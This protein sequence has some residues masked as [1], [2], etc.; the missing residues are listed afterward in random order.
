MAAM[1]CARRV[2][3]WALVTSVLGCGAAPPVRDPSAE[4]LRARVGG[5]LP[6]TVSLGEARYVPVSARRDEKRFGG[7]LEGA[8]ALVNGIRLIELPNGGVLSATSPLPSGGVTES[9]V[10]EV[11]SRMGGGF[12][13]LIGSSVHRADDWLSP[14][15]PIFTAPTAPAS[16]IVR[17]TVGLDRVYLQLDRGTWVPIDP[18]DGQL[19]DLGTFPRAP[20]VTSL[21]TLDGWRAAALADARGVVVT[22]DAGATWTPIP[23][24]ANPVSL[25]RIGDMLVVK[26]GDSSSS[27]RTAWF[28]INTD[29]RVGRLARDPAEEDDAPTGELEEAPASTPFGVRPLVAAIE[30]GW[31]LTDGTALVARDGAIGRVRMSDGA[32]VEIARDVFPLRPARCHPFSL[33]RPTSPAAFGFACGTPRGATE[34]YAYDA[35]AGAPTLLRRFDKPRV[36]ASSGNGA[37][38]IR[39]ACAQDAPSDDE[40]RSRQTYCVLGHDNRFTDFVVQGEIGAQRIVVLA[41]GR[42]A[43]IAPP[44]AGNLAGASVT[45]LDKGVAK[46]SP[47]IWEP[48]AP[49]ERAAIEHV[50][51]NGTWLESFEERKPGKLSGWVVTGHV[52]I[53]IEIGADGHARHGM[54]VPDMGTTI[55]SSAYGIGWSSHGYETIDG[56]MT[57]HQVDMPLTLPADNRSDVRAACGPLGCE[58]GGWLRVGWGGHPNQSPSAPQTIT[59]ER[60]PGYS[61][62]HLLCEAASKLTVQAQ[63]YVPVPPKAKSYEWQAFYGVN[64]PKLVD[65]DYAYG[66][67]GP[68]VLTGTNDTARSRRTGDS[69]VRTLAHYYAWGPRSLDWETKG[70]SMAR[71]SSPFEPS[72]S[73]HSTQLG[74]IPHFVGLA[75]STLVTQGRF[76]SVLDA[77]GVAFGDDGAHALWVFAMRQGNAAGALLLEADRGATEIRRTDGY[78]LGAIDSAVRAG[79]RWYLTTPND[80]DEP[81]ATIVWEVEA[82]VAHELARLPRISV[83][84]Q[85]QQSTA[86]LGVRI[87][88]SADNRAVGVVIDGQPSAKRYITNQRWVVPIDLAT[89]KVMEPEPIGAADATSAATICEPGAGGWVMDVGYTNP[90][91]IGTDSLSSS[92]ARVHLDHGAACIERV[93]STSEIDP[94]A[95]SKHLVDADSPSVEVTAM[96]EGVRVLLHCIRSR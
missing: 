55:V 39:G 22:T 85:W 52:A 23:L 12:L 48:D 66:L 93:I 38:W 18:K 65:D 70:R 68:S 81:N 88:R 73:V 57:W 76:G 86:T 83:P 4:Q 40:A 2:V 1:R 27:D 77:G 34:I 3:A 24:P 69:N 87:A 47:I 33:A 45:V 60:S 54:F 62:L 14:T 58:A 94:L 90:L 71:W 29:G 72:T 75:V 95:L 15:H 30:D 78:D 50:L 49:S 43:V 32:L 51:R 84:T 64:S 82:G 41:D 89:G 91:W 35:L 13:F 56:G 59:V 9:G 20:F 19:L 17:M 46:T 10:L 28:E 96:H 6:F 37:I 67:E 92:V 11:P 16:S 74:T 21:V 31:P 7:S 5:S 44:V 26:A 25:D 36:V 79:G 8:R 80:A 61:P 42:R 63:P 53:G